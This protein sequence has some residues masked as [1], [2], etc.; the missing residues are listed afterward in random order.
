MQRFPAASF[1][2][3]QLLYVSGI[4]PQVRRLSF[5][6]HPHEGKIPF[7][8]IQWPKVITYET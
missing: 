6:S 3:T 7:V 4:I 1:F 8:S 2:Y 5:L